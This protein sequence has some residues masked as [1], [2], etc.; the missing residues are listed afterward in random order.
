MD[1]ELKSTYSVRIR[2]TAANQV[3]KEE[4]FTLQVADQPEGT[5]GNDLFTARLGSGGITVQLGSSDLGIFP[6]DRPLTFYGLGGNDTINFL[7]GTSDDRVTFTANGIGYRNQ[8]LL[9]NGIEGIAIRLGEGADTFQIDASLPGVQTVTLDGGTGD[10]LYRF[11]PQT[12][13]GVLRIDESKAG[14]DILDF[15]QDTNGVRVDL[16]LSGTQVVSPNLQLILLPGS[17]FEQ[18]VGGAGN[19]VLIGDAFDNRLFGNAGND[20]LS[21]GAGNDS[22]II[23]MNSPQGSDTLSDRSGYDTIDFS[24]SNILGAQVN[25]SISAPQVVSA[26][27]TLA[28]SNPNSFEH[29]VGRS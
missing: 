24:A 10:D 13:L 7:G 1:F 8:E 17:T 22:Y 27:Y 19:D 2:S 15:T 6:P 14:Y 28:L 12:N 20:S 9:L 25:L 26:N 18:L 5:S 11:H 4:T 3:F 16:G 29:I 21:G 23:N